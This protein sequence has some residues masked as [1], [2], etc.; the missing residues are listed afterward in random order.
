MAFRDSVRAG[1]A[2]HDVDGLDMHEGEFLC[3]LESAILLSPAFDADSF[4]ARRDDAT[5]TPRAARRRPLRARSRLEVGVTTD[6]LRVVRVGGSGGGPPVFAIPWRAVN[7]IEQIPLATTKTDVLTHTAPSQGNALY[8]L[9]LRLTA[10]SAERTWKDKL[11]VLPIEVDSHLFS[12]ARVAWFESKLASS[13]WRLS[14]PPPSPLPSLSPSSAPSFPSPAS[15]PEFLDHLLV[16][17]GAD[18]LLSTDDAR[19]LDAMRDALRHGGGD[20]QPLARL[21]CQELLFKSTHAWPV[22]AYL[23]RAWF[24]AIATNA[25]DASHADCTRPR[26]GGEGERGVRDEAQAGAEAESGRAGGTSDTP[27]LSVSASRAARQRTRA[28]DGPSFRRLRAWPASLASRE[29]S[30]GT[31]GKGARRI[32]VAVAAAAMAGP[33]RVAQRWRALARGLGRAL[34]LRKLSSALCVVRLCLE[35]AVAIPS[36]VAWFHSRHGALGMGGGIGGGHGAAGGVGYGAGAAMAHAFCMQDLFAVALRCVSHFID[37][38]PAN[39]G[40]ANARKAKKGEGKAAENQPREGARGSTHT[41][42]PTTPLGGRS[43][44]GGGGG[45]MGSGLGALGA[46]GAGPQEGLE[47]CLG[48]L[49]YCLEYAQEAAE[50]YSYEREAFALEATRSLSHDELVRACGTM[51]SLVLHPPDPPGVVAPLPA[52]HALRVLTSLLVHQPPSPSPSY[53]SSSSLSPSL[54]QE[55]KRGVVAAVKEA[56]E[57]DLEFFCNGLDVLERVGPKNPRLEQPIVE[58]VGAVNALLMPHRHGRT[59]KAHQGTGRHHLH[60]RA[61]AA[62]RSPGPKEGGAA[63]GSVRSPAGASMWARLRKGVGTSAQEATPT[64]SRLMRKAIA[65]A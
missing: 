58:A 65:T 61:R 45:E 8:I 15:P 14:P 28:F 7:G 13:S 25:D 48:I 57:T 62:G 39:H 27:P 16:V 18:A 31:G 2:K 19:S 64:P 33:S 38:A 56:H 40:L 29:G 30:A 49:F 21:Q 59:A 50:K 3:R 51:L 23:T 41:K 11:D 42:G 55:E 4:A 1:L 17:L 46:L 5:G 54:S 37:Q 47:A 26:A 9:R 44:G 60:A 36:R 20:T 12:T 22:I 10:T 24:E 35:R 52:Y 43:E 32:G 34:L 6:F 53:G 63:G